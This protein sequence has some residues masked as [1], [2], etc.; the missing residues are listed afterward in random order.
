MITWKNRSNTRKNY[1]ADIGDLHVI[2][3][4]QN[5]CWQLSMCIRVYSQDKKQNM[6]RPAVIV[7]KFDKDCTA[8]EAKALTYEYIQDFLCGISTALI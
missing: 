1:I 2:L 5:S 4:R 6:L 7:N 3:K 8:E